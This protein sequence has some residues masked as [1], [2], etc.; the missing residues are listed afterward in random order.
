MK[1]PII[2]V[3]L[4]NSIQ[5]KP[6]QRFSE[7]TP[8]LEFAIKRGCKNVLEIGAADG[9]LTFIFSCL[10]DKVVAVDIKHTATYNKENIIRVQA[11]SHSSNLLG[12]Y[13]LIL[14]DGDH[15]LEGVKKD[16]YI[17]KEML[18]KDGIM[19]LHDIKDTEI[20]RHNGC[21]VHKFIKEGKHFE[22][23]KNT[24]VFNEFTDEWGGVY[25][26]EMK[27]HGGIQIWFN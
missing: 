26:P 13:D 19:A 7:L 2:D 8:F 24:L 11:D 5:Y 12:M 15:S 27:N 3:A 16:F 18:H 20:Q 10:F 4:I 21:F 25:N 9:G 14:I 23:W 1:N 6:Q 22:Q 17:Y